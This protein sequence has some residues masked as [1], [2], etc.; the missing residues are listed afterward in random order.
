MIKPDPKLE[1]LV[2]YGNL[3]LSTLF[4]QALH[5]TWKEQAEPDYT[6]VPILLSTVQNVS[7][8][9][10]RIRMRPQKE[11]TINQYEKELVTAF[12][13]SGFGLV[14]PW[15][16]TRTILWKFA[17]L[18]YRLSRSL[19]RREGLGNG[20]QAEGLASRSGGAESSSGGAVQ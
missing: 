8:A 4:L 17:G 20:N 15:Q 11:H 16:V 9:G 14:V 6:W 5:E 12:C 7:A 2:V 1:S 10:I 13:V 3:W 18:Q 19:R